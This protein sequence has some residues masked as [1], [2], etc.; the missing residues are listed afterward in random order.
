MIIKN[1]E[2]AYAH[3]ICKRVDRWFNR[4]RGRFRVKLQVEQSGK[5][6]IVKIEQVR[7]RVGKEFCG[8]HPAACEVGNPTHRKGA[9]LE[10]ADWVQFNDELNNILDR[11]GVSARVESAQVILRKGPLRRTHYGHRYP[12]AGR[13]AEW[14]RGSDRE[15]DWQNHRYAKKNLPVS[16]FD[17]GTPGMYRRAGH[18]KVG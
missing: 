4:S 10:G 6:Q 9:Y 13:N 2:G 15:W 5:Q 17:E 11:M 3:T 18:Q 16:T 12:S 8:N 7:L 14:K 1:I